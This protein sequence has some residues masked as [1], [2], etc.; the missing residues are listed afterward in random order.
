MA[1]PTP[2]KTNRTAGSGAA[3]P[4]PFSPGTG[5][6]SPRARSVG[7]VVASVILLI[8]GGI[9]FMMLAVLSLLLGMVS[10]GCGPVTKCD[11]DLM[12]VGYV[13]VVAGPPVIYIA[14]VIWTILRLKRGRR[15]WW[16]PIVGALAALAVWG[17]GYA[18]LVASIGR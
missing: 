5:P 16:V 17:A 15:G 2:G 7:D 6:G 11:F 9:G 8:A 18:M 13:I 12:G 14:A 3:P 4:T 1:D 10:D